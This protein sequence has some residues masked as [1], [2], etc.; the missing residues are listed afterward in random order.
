VLVIGP[1]LRRRGPRERGAAL[2]IVV[3]W[4]PVLLVVFMFVVDV[5][6]WFVHKRHLQMQAD[7]G[8]LAGGGVFHIPCSDTPILDETRNYAG[9]PGAATPYN[10]QLAPTQQANVHVLVNSTTYWNKGGSDFS[11]TGMPCAAKFVD[12]KMTEA[13][14]PWYMRLAVVPAIN[15]HARVSILQKNGGAGSLPV[16][17]PDSNPVA[18]AA[19]YVNEVN[20]AVVGIQA[21]TNTQPVTANGQSL[22]LWTGAAV[23]ADIQ[24]AHTGVVVALSGKNGWVPSGT[25]SQ[26]CNQ[27]L[28][29]CYQ[30]GDTGPWLGLSHIQGYATTGTGSPTAPILRDVSLYPVGC[31]DDSAAYFLLN[32]GVAGCSIG[33]KAKVDF[34]PVSSGNPELPVNQGGLLAQV[35][36]EAPGCPSSGQAPK[37]CV[38]SY[39]TTGPNAGYWLTSGSNGYPVISGTTSLSLNWGTGSGNTS[40]TGTF[41]NVQRSFVASTTNSGPIDYV[42][43]AD[44]TLSTG[45]HTVNA[46]VAIKGSLQANATSVNDPVV[47]LKVTGGGS[48]NQALDCDPNVSTLRDEI[49]YGCVPQY[50]KNTGQACPAFNAPLWTD[51][52]T[53]PWNCVRVSTGNSAGQVNQGLLTRIQ[54]GS[55]SCVHPNN[56]SSFPNLPAGDPRIV[57]VFLVPFGAFGGSGSNNV[58]PVTGFATFYVTGWSQGNGG[59]QGDPCP[60]ADAVNGGGEITGHFIKYVDTINTGGGGPACDFNSFGTC[61]AV[62]TE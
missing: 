19:I 31:T 55:N 4:L 30:G 47:H 50:V 21:L 10:L 43:L 13:N 45:T 3:V 25:L 17:V 14:L 59:Q 18:A 28:V 44:N 6:N 60:G 15:A 42:V 22:T 48:L 56:W 32:T 52:S 41:S 58:V 2:V 38:M 12:V 27:V 46:A 24:S 5:G 33:V 29:Q 57:P 34:G 11:D 9:D 20:G 35:K 53:Q 16:A 49:A 40:T 7:A 37:G 54:D 26:I 51:P 23:S 8:A 61:V 1:D 62:L 39:Q 36:V